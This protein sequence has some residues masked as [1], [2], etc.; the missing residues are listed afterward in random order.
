MELKDIE[1]YDSKKMYQVYDKWPQ[2]AK[3]SFDSKLKPVNYSQ[4]DNIIFAGMGGSGTLGDI[5]SSILS[6]TNIHVSV[7]KGYHLPKTADSKTLVIATSISG[8][9]VETLSVLKSALELPCK[10]IAFSSNGKMENFCEEN[11]IDFRKISME[12][13]PRASFTRFFYG[14]LKVLQP[15]LPINK[16]DI[17]ESLIQLEKL[18]RKI[19]SKNLNDKNEALSLAKWITGIPAIYFPAGLNA[20]AIRFK[21]SLQE[22]SKMHT[23]AE[24]V[25]EA[26]HNGIMSWESL[27]N[28]QPILLQGEDDFPKTKERWNIL[29]E[30][31]NNK[32]IE[33]QEV[34]SVRGSIISKLINLIYL[35]D[36]TSIYVAIIN[37][38]D[39]TSIDSINFVKER[40]N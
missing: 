20:A 34:H 17:E 8:N 22:N 19:S 10:I 36:Y 15:I 18:S 2:I 7:V 21:N 25:I 33:F 40:L 38:T 28:V 26:C 9:T 6:K 24:D 1:S 11:K 35:L 29:K 13:S 3:E 14:M 27:S 23:I 32:Q 30:F 37:K 12:H 5:F 16:D 39:P 31:F 4:I